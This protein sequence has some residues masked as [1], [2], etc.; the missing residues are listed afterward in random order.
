METNISFTVKGT[1]IWLICA[2]FFLYEFLLRTVIGTFQHPIMYDLELTT[3]QFAILS[4]TVYLFIYAVMQ[5]PVGLLV[6][7]IGLK[8]SLLIGA[9]IC[10]LS[11]IGFGLSYGYTTAI[12]FRFL[13]GLGSSFGFICLLISVR[14]I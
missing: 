6:D 4:S 9:S 1:F 12:F 13:T 14:I 3:F 10:A 7:R 8:K 11:S 2:A 5:I